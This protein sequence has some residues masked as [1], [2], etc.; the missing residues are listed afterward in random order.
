MQQDRSVSPDIKIL[1]A[2]SKA[3]TCQG[4]GNYQG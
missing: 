4:G 2:T 1:Q 3:T